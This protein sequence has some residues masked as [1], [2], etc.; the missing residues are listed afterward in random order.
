MGTLIAD[1]LLVVEDHP[2]VLQ[3]L[4]SALKR[5]GSH[6][7]SA[8]TLRAARQRV[9]EDDPYDAVIC[10]HHLSDGSGLEF[11]GWLRWQQHIPVPFLLIA[12]SDKLAVPRVPD[13]EVLSPPLGPD[14]LLA[15]LSSLLRHETAGMLICQIPFAGEIEIE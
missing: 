5:C 9:L 2:W 10:E 12:R 4:C 13:F 7:E 1:R 8:T 14:R 6:I 15:S 3:K 11:L